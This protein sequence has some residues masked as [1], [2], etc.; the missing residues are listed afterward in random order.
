[1]IFKSDNSDIVT[2]L[3]FGLK[4][5]RRGTVKQPSSQYI[6]YDLGVQYKKFLTFGIKRI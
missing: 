3:Q 4:K 5:Q 1:M 2:P 6:Y